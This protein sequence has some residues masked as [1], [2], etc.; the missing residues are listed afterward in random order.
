MAVVQ[1]SL[2]AALPVMLL[3][4]GGVPSNLAN[5]HAD[6][7]RRCALAAA[8]VALL[9]SVITG[10]VLLRSG[11]ID[12]AL[13]SFT[14]P[15]SFSFGVYLDSLS[16]VMLLLISFVG[17]IIVRYSI[18]YLDREQAQGRFL[19]WIVFTLGA[20]LSLVV[21]RNLLML[22]AGWMMTSFGLHQLLTHYP[23]RSWAVWAA[24]K[25]FLISRLGDVM[26]LSALAMT[27]SCLGT[28]EYSEVFAAV[29]ALSP[30]SPLASF[31]IPVIGSLYV[32][33][34]M[35]KSAQVPFHSWLPDTM[36]APTPVSALMHAGIINAGGFLVLRLSP[37][38][39]LS[40]LALDVLALIG[41]FTALMGA[42]V[43]LTQTSVKRQ[44]AYSTMA[45]MGFMMFQCGLGAFSAAL[46]HIVAHSLYKAHAFLSSGSVLDTAS[47]MKVVGRNET[48]TRSLVSLFVA[49]AAALAICAAGA[50]VL[51]GDLSAKPGGLILALVLTLALTQLLWPAFSTGSMQLAG[52]SLLAAAA[53]SFSYYGA[54]TATDFLLASSVSHQKV[55]PSLFDSLVTAFVGA[56][57]VAIFLLQAATR[58]AAPGP[59]MQSLYVHAT[60]GFYLDIPA[61]RVTAWAWGHRAPTQ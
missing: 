8:S 39:S 7:M 28:V 51:A 56:G 48:A 5:R 10:F 6:L 34:A 45:Q 12:L 26:L 31:W 37:L 15:I 46:L 24:R 19:K 14:W 54:Y 42:V 40:H 59:L 55:S 58:L 36:E 17:V 3:L 53:V 16:A 23:D 44:L 60:H 2:M 29:Q 25:K 43:M 13:A 27:Y 22:T 52:G 21:S 49:I 33:G 20:V 38:I 50:S 32:L 41:G 47:G 30:Q 4:F 9:L 1:S 18:R 35:T 61:R 11:P 57:F